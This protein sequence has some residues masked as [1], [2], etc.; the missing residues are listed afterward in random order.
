MIFPFFLFLIGR[1]NDYYYAWESKSKFL[2]YSGFQNVL[3]ERLLSAQYFGKSLGLKEKL[4][5]DHFLKAFCFAFKW[6]VHVSDDV[7]KDELPFGLCSLNWY[8]IFEL[9]KC[10]TIQNCSP[11]RPVKQET[12]FL[13]LNLGENFT[14]RANPL[15]CGLVSV[16]SS[17]EEM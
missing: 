17:P 6:I 1:V 2:V 8:I 9:E 16:A 15:S 3:L 13:H 12:Y 10:S 5:W 4:N 11:A 14:L 7:S